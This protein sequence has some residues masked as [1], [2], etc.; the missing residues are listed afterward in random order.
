MTPSPD[1]VIQPQT[2]AFLSRGTGK[3]KGEF[4]SAGR[5]IRGA[6]ISDVHFGR[7]RKP[8]RRHRGADFFGVPSIQNDQ[9]RLCSQKQPGRLS[10][11]QRRAAQGKVR[12]ETGIG[13][14]RQGHQNIVG[15][16]LEQLMLRSLLDSFGVRCWR[17]RRILAGNQQ[18]KERD[19]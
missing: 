9:L 13:S 8:I 14:G 6:T 15:D 16:S 17:G 3:A 1:L 18:K 11:S 19:Q 4:S 10:T 2:P 7:S 12:F 5:S